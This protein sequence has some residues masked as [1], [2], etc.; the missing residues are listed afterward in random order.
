MAT[1]IGCISLGALRNGL[2]LM[3]VCAFYRL[4]AK[5]IIITAMLIDR[6]TPGKRGADAET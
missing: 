1:L 4:L 3:S 5:G 6:A 2:T